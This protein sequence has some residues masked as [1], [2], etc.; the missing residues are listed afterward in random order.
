MARRLMD[1]SFSNRPSCSPPLAVASS[2]PLSSLPMCDLR[3]WAHSRSGVGVVDV[4]AESRAVACGGPLQHLEVA[5][6][7]AE[8]GNRATTNVTLD[9]RRPFLSSLSTRVGNFIRTCIL[10]RLNEP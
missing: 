2:R 8:G 1:R 9:A 10:S 3:S 7:V 5:I 6:G 4:E